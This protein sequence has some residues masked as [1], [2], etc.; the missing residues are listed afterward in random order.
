MPVLDALTSHPTLLISDAILVLLQPRKD[1]YAHFWC[2]HSMDFL[3]LAI[4]H[5]IAQMAATR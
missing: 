3:F 2:S 5:P 4:N 1:F